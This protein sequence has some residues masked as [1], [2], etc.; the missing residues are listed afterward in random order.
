MFFNVLAGLTNVNLYFLLGFFVV[1]ATLAAVPSIVVLLLRL[2]LM[3]L[4]LF[5]TYIQ[6]LCKRLNKQE[7]S[8]VATEEEPPANACTSRFEKKAAR[9]VGADVIY[10]T[11]PGKAPQSASD[12]PA[13]VRSHVASIGYAADRTYQQ[14]DYRRGTTSA[15][16]HQM[17]G[18]LEPAGN[19]SLARREVSSV[20]S[21]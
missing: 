7:G 4:M 17:K 21:R 18:R 12:R 20:G 14:H 15:D 2:P 11:A 10:M 16:W 9:T 8:Q 5:I 1:L 13:M 3:L 6:K 19:S